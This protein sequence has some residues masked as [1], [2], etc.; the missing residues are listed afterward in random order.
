M[1]ASPHAVYEA[2]TTG[3]GVRDWWSSHTTDATNGEITVRFG[4]EDFH[5]LRLLNLTPDKHVV[6][7]WI[8]QYF[9]VPGTSQ[10]DEWVGTRVLFDIHANP[11]GSSTLHFM[12]AGLT[13]HVACY[14]LCE[15]GWNNALGNLQR[16]LEH[17]VRTA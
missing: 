4:G 3:A 14:N 11:D 9:P 16:F 5:T 6:W 8:A 15:P 1:Q 17:G 12:H 2:V 13:P 10:T 7:E